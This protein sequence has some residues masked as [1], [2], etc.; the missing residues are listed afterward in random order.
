MFQLQNRIGKIASTDAAG[1]TL[2]AD[3]AVVT[4]REGLTDTS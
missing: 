1:T 4:M 3:C 2:G